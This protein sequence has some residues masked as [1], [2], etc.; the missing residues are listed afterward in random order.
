MFVDDYT[1]INEDRMP[2]WILCRKKYS[3]EDFLRFHI[4]ENT[5]TF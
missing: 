1:N 4:K 2:I 5:K 3:E